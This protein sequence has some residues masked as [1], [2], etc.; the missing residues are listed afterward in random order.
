MADSKPPP[1]EFNNSV[2]KNDDNDKFDERRL[3]ALVPKGQKKKAKYLLNQFNERG[4]ELTW[5]SDGVIFVNQISV[6]GSNIIE[7]F[8]FLYKSLK[9]KSVPRLLDFLAKIKD[10]GLQD[11]IVW[12]PKDFAKL[13]VSKNQNIEQKV[14]EKSESNNWWFL[15]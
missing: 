6:P 1:V 10:M 11:F 13:E 14:N 2:K 3:L 7:L 5:N 8:P 4:D 15:N 12:S 9:P